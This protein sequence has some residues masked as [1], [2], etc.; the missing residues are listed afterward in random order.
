[1]NPVLTIWVLDN[2][3]KTSSVCRRIGPREL[4]KVVM[5]VALAI[6]YVGESSAQSFL[7]DKAGAGE[8]ELL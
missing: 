8:S 7:V 1:M 3:D 5:A 2:E 4:G 6:D